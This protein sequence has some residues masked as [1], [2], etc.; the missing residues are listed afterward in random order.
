M[1][2]MD[3]ADA[4]EFFND[5]V[6]ESNP[7]AV[8]EPEREYVLQA[9]T[10]RELKVGL[11]ACDRKFVI[12]QL[13]KLPDELLELFSEV[14]DPE[15][16]QEKADASNALTGLSGDAIEAFEN[17]CAESMQH[18]ELSDVQM[19][20]LASQLDLEVLFEIGAIVIEISL[21]DSGRIT[22]FRVHE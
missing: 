14:D 1:T 15:E 7:H 17:L 19:T 3:Q 22:G 4:L 20:Q 12:D 11:I 9:A 5:V 18:V 8:P 21:E 6:G 2:D 16:A 10:G 13:N